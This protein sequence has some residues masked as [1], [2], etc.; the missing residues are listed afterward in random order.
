MSVSNFIWLCLY[1]PLVVYVLLL[2]AW[3]WLRQHLLVKETAMQDLPLLGVSRRDGDKIKGTAVICGGS[4]SGLLIA[5][6]CHD[7]FERVLIVEPESWLF[8]RDGMLT[9]AWTQKNKRTRVMQYRSAQGAIQIMGFL[10]FKRLFPSLEDEC[11]AS[12]IRI[13]PA[14]YKQRVRGKVAP[15]PYNYFKG[16]IPK[17]AYWARPGVETL[18]RRLV[19]GQGKYPNIYTISGTVTAVHADPLDCSRIQ[20]VTVRTTSDTQD[21]D[22]AMVSD[23][24]G[25]S[26]GMKWLDRAG[27]GY[28]TSY[29][30]GSLPMD[31][32]RITFDHQMHYS[33]LRYTIPLSMN[34]KLPVPGGL[35]N[36]GIL[37]SCLT[38][39]PSDG[40]VISISRVEGNIVEVICG[41]WGPSDLPIDTDT[42]ESYI[43]GFN[44]TLDEPIPTWILDTIAQFHEPSITF[45]HEAVRTP[46]AFYDRYQYGVNLPNNMIVTGDAVMRINPIYGQGVFKAELG[47]IALNTVLSATKQRDPRR[48][49]SDFAKTFFNTQAAKIEPCWVGT[50]IGDYGFTTTTPLP[51]ETLSTGAWLRW[52]SGRLLLLSGVDDQASS[53]LWHTKMFLAPGIDYFHPAL[54]AK[55]IWGALTG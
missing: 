21:I 49:P 23:C 40:R 6:V 33:T 45:T 52:Y 25:S 7:H 29:P 41:T 20:K 18:L 27:Y 50:K 39:Y 2:L 51:G 8:T 26:A 55:V 47:A 13:L 24:T 12:D 35:Q 17:T 44:A 14:D 38:D 28:E 5:R 46:P 34:D 4:I 19:L 43:T 10:G 30:K 9:Q 3:K 32:L 36:S 16:N 54:L 31:Q 15:A 42:L 11:L 1:A 48:L 53:V 22:A 37:Y